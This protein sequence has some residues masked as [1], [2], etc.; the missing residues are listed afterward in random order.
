MGYRRFARAVLL[1]A[2][3]CSSWFLPPALAGSRPGGETADRS[4]S[5]YF[6]VQ[7]DDPNVDRL[8]LKSTKV[9]VRIVGVIADVSVTQHYKNEGRRPLEARYVFPGS[10][11]AAVYAM[12]VRLGDRLLT[13]RIREKTKARAQYRAAKR[14]GKTAALLEQHRSNV[15]QMNVANILPD[16]DV[17]VELRYTELVVP[18]DGTYEFVF[19]TVVGPRYNGAPASGSGTREKWLATPYLHQGQRS[20]T[21]FDLALRLASPIPL[22]AVTSPSHRIA[23]Q[24]VSDTE[25]RVTLADTGTNENNRDVV[26]DYRL[27]GDR[28]QSG[29]L[30]S[31]GG[32]DGEKF[33]LAMVEPPRAVAAAQ[34]VPRD[35]VFIVDVSGSMYGF[36][37]DTAKVLLENL[38]GG[39][40]PS[41]TF[42]LML[43]SGASRVLAPQSL[44]ATPANVARAVRMLR[45]QD[46]G[47]ATELVPALQRALSMPTDADRARTFVVITDGYVSVERN[48]FQLIRRNL[49]KANLFAFGIGT[50]VNRALIE[51]MARAGQGE[52][53]VVLDPRAAAPAA[54]RFRRMIE[55]PVLTRLTARFE[56]LD[57][58]DIEPPALPDVF[59]RRPVVLFGKWRGQPTG[60]LVLD[61]RAANG[62]FHVAPDLHD[63]HASEKNG[64]LRY[65]WARQRVASLS[66]QEALDGDDAQRDAIT[67]LGLRYNLLTRYTS[68]IAVDRV[69][70]NPVP[71][72]VT[73]VDQPSPLPQGVSDL[74]VGAPV[75][76]T[77]E[78]P[79]TALLVIAGLALLIA[80][81]RHRPR[82]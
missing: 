11:R 74:A 1:F 63:A 71:T 43:F 6:F 5:P 4:E 10:T 15:F 7:S 21:R 61:G 8:P 51:G 30:L 72:D 22:Q 48:V 45:E 80:L 67:Q 54:E 26:L 18:T 42:N 24:R 41:D 78:P 37:L 38:V 40:R 12:N 39:L 55:A 64:A 31:D 20:G 52:P 62:P 13:A 36:P 34:V 50:S 60:R 68:F 77:P 46:G 81:R 73:G 82:G 56:G 75:P 17:R 66:D 2:T 49:S 65:L 33:F 47:G 32:K 58:Y 14:E 44:P 79:V 3:V 16:D 27:A 19:P 57:V 69:V 29:V 59:A 28:I 35:Y 76:S 70:R 9:D 25:A 23:V 53:F